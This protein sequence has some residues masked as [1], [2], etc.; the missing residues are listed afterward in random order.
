MELSRQRLMRMNWRE[1][2]DLKNID[3]KFTLL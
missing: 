3:W 2:N 1:F